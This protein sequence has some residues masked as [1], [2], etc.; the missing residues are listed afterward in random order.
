MN[1]IDRITRMEE[2]LNNALKAVEDLEKA[3]DEYLK[4]DAGIEELK[5][6]YGSPVWFKDV[7]DDDQGLLPE[8]LRRGVLSED[9]IYN[10]LY[11]HTFLLQKMKAILENRKK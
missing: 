7:E 5:E 1:Q 4:V 2:H 8:D 3:L 11:D 10:M 6:Y 9:G